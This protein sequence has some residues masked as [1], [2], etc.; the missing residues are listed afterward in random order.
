V[1]SVTIILLSN[2][3]LNIY[4]WVRIICPESFRVVGDKLFDQINLLGNLFILYD[5][6][7]KW[8]IQ[9]IWSIDCTSPQSQFGLSFSFHSFK[10]WLH[11]PWPVRMRLRR[12]HVFRGS[13]VPNCGIKTQL[14]SSP[15]GGRF[16]CHS[17][18]IIRTNHSEPSRYYV[19]S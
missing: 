3:F 19:R 15:F 9:V 6:K 5:N 13:S 14:T 12:T 16:L 18:I 10:S 8:S 17:V 7:Y 1:P 2:A 4:T 11:R